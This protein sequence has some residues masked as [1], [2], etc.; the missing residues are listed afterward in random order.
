MDGRDQAMRNEVSGPAGI[1]GLAARVVARLVDRDGPAPAVLRE[2]LILRFM[3]AVIAP[4]QGGVEAMFA[5]MRRA[6]VSRTTFAD[7]YI[8]EIARRLG[9]AWEDDSL[10]FADVTVGMSRLQAILREIGRDWSADHDPVPVHGAATVLLIVPDNEQHTLGAMVLMGL[11]RRRGISVALRIAPTVADL[12]TLLGGRAF[13]AALV[14]VGQSSGVAPC[15]AL[16]R[17]LREATGDRLPI[18]VGGAVLG[19]MQD[20][21]EQTGADVV[22]N[23]LGAVITALGLERA[24]RGPHVVQD[25]ARGRE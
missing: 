22:S 25:T 2:D 23:D 16:V 19:L 18:A 11:L 5:E 13:D 24:A 7:R 9:R 21:R 15:R 10:G 3:D 4:S 17:A 8:P 1:A 20:V 14:S 6:G 12:R